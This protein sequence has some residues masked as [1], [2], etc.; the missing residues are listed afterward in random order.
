MG[1]IGL[2]TDQSVLTELRDQS[3]N[4]TTI[5]AK[6]LAF[7]VSIRALSLQDVRPSEY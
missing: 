5:L 6:L 1:K 2:E 7:A 3:T 4:K